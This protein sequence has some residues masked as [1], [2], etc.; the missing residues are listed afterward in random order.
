MRKADMEEN[1]QG[2]T[3][4]AEQEQ[5]RRKNGKAFTTSG[6]VLFTIELIAGIIFVGLIILGIVLKLQGG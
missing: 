5:K 6:K 3:R 4:I 2:W 1:E